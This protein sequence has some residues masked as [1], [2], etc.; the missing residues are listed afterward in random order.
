MTAKELIG[1]WDKDSIIKFDRNE[2]RSLGINKKTIDILADI[3]LP[4]NAPS[5]LMFGG[6]HDG[7]TI[8]DIYG[9]NNPDDRFLIEIGLDAAGDTIC[10]DTKNDCEIVACAHTNNFQKRF[11]NS[12]ILELLHFI[13]LYKDF[14]ERL[15]SNYLDS[16]LAQLIRQFENVDRKALD[17]GTYWTGEIQN[18]KADRE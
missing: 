1:K 4:E 18:L 17:R 16:E 7:K 6:L 14:E 15:E 10:V 3:G 11:M 8:A 5:L 13:T 2:L 9:T 12:S